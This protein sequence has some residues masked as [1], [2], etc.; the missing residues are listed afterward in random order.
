M[1]L[2]NLITPSAN[3]AEL[4][5]IA[6]EHDLLLLRQD[7]VYLAHKAALPFP[8]KVL[9]LESDVTWRNITLPASIRA[10]SDAEWVTL[11]AKACQNLLWS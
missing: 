2:I 10:I 5:G 1:K 11:S 3:L 6:N 9:A 4:S 7:A 8:G